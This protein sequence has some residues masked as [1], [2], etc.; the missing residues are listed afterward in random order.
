MLRLTYNIISGAEGL[1]KRNSYFESAGF[2]LC[3]WTWKIKW[4]H[5]KKVCSSICIQ[6]SSWY[7]LLIYCEKRC[8]L[9]DIPTRPLNIIQTGQHLNNGVGCKATLFLVEKKFCEGKTKKKSV[10][11][12]QDK[13]VGLNID[14]FVSHA[15]VISYESSYEKRQQ[16]IAEENKSQ[17]QLG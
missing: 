5:S 7:F 6:H 2:T 15:S 4:Q 8:S 1:Y 11:A 9:N 16:H 13:N 17:W 12:S 3:V 14:W 10:A